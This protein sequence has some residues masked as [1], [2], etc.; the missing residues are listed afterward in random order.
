MTDK[1]AALVWRFERHAEMGTITAKH[2]FD[3]FS[4]RVGDLVLGAEAKQRVR[5]R[6]TLGAAA[7]YVFFAALIAVNVHIGL[8][9]FSPQFAWIF[10]ILF[11]LTGFYIAIRSGWSLRFRDP[12]MTTAQMGMAITTL[13]IFYSFNPAIRGGF[14]VIQGLVLVFGGFTLTPS[15]CRRLGWFAVAAMGVSMALSAMRAPLVFAPRIECQYFLF[16]V[17][18]LP[19]IASLS[20]QLSAL[21]ANLKAKNRALLEALAK[22]NRIAIEDQLT[23]LPNRRHVQ[24]LL[25]QDAESIRL[26]PAP[27][28]LVMIDIDNFK[29]INDTRGHAAG[30]IVL[31][32]FAEL[33][34]GHL[35]VDDVLARWG[36]EEFLLVLPATIPEAGMVVEHL[37]VLISQ[38]RDWHDH[39]PLQ[40][41]F[42]AGIAN[43][44]PGE[45]MEKTIERADA[46]LYQAKVSGRDR[47]LTA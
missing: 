32:R 12:A 9:N 42:S 30:D 18:V 29:R 20:G 15:R 34:R 39:T 43:H 47:W 37:R 31:R 46:A 26:H 22:I 11:C 8:A 45:C 41:T 27:L 6:R 16:S 1:T 2:I 7:I 21:R 19:A 17:I 5:L 25:A 28:C 10:F 38:H 3:R 40:V 24:E 35:R 23:G 33:A 14:L 36:G 4:T 44:E 13:A